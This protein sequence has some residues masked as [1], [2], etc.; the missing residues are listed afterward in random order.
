MELLLNRILVLILCY[1]RQNFFPF[2][3]FCLSAVA[4]PVNC[5]PDGILSL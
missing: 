1:K 2:F 4:V 5:I 3:V